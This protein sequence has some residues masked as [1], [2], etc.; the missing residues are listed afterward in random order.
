MLGFGVVV[1]SCGLK[2]KILTFYVGF[3]R[4][5]FEVENLDVLC[6][7]WRC[8]LKLKILTFYVRI[9]CCCLKLWFEVENLDVLCWVLAVWF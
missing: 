8:G 6:W 9:W 4:C 1:W 2:L 7:V 3:R 5:G